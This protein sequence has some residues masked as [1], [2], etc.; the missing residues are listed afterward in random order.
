MV[1]TSRVYRRNNVA[2]S[3]TQSWFTL[4]ELL[5]VIAI[6]AILASLLLPALSAAREKARIVVCANRLRQHG[7]AHNLYKA[8]F[9]GYFPGFGG[10]VA[11]DY[12]NWYRTNGAANGRLMLMMGSA[13]QTYLS[14]YVNADDTWD[15]QKMFRCPVIEWNAKDSWPAPFPLAS[16]WKD[17]FAQ[18]LP[19]YHRYAGY[20]F[21]TGRKLHRPGK[22][23]RSFD[24]RLPRARGGEILVTD[25]VTYSKKTNWYFN[26]HYAQSGTLG[27]QGRAQQVTAGGS[28][29]SFRV[30]DANSTVGP[31]QQKISFYAD[32]KKIGPPT[33]RRDGKF[34]IRR[35][36]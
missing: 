16:W 2:R 33:S 26:P 3:Y 31:T 32:A 34:W 10:E 35:N 18:V 1:P 15:S 17:R 6:I 9:D 5:V 36:E 28:V 8:D 24:T 13:A 27:P 7:V 22:P 11:N 4:I 19:G 14:Q 30:P 23:W 29:S 25:L 21:Y 20:A 12:S